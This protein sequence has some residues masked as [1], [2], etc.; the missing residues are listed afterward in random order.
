ML[1]AISDHPIPGSAT[2]SF[3]SVPLPVSARN[4]VRR[5]FCYV[6]SVDVQS[7]NDIVKEGVRRDRHW[8]HRPFVDIEDCGVSDWEIDWL[9]HVSIMLVYRLVPNNNSFNPLR[10]PK[11]T[12]P[13]LL[14]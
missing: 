2:R 13:K 6:S 9:S 14:P 12:K 10:R 1:P 4:R 8:E 7:G 5:W 11:R 3:E